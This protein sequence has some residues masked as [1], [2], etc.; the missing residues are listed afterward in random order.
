MNVFGNTRSMTGMIL[1]LITTETETPK[2][3]TKS[4]EVGMTQESMPK[5]NTSGESN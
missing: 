2:N 3:M 5:I 4:D 1:Y